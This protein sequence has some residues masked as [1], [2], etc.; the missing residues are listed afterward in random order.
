M[1][2]P[3]EMD[4]KFPLI[5]TRGTHR[6]VQLL[7]KGR[8]ASSILRNTGEGVVFSGSKAERLSY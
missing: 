7:P 8:A 5:S 6:G 3:T 4:G 2:F 1:R